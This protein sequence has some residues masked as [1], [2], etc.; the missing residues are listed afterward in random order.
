V[1]SALLR[2]SVTQI[3][4]TITGGSISPLLPPIERGQIERG[5]IERGQRQDSTDPQEETGGTIQIEE[6]EAPGSLAVLDIA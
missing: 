1:K 3:P 2:Q 5:Q 4:A 6:S